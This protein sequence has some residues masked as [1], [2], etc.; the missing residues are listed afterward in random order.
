MSASLQRLRG[1]VMGAAIALS[2]APATAQPRAD[3]AASEAERAR[4]AQPVATL[5]GATITVGELEDLLNAA[6]APIRRGYQQLEARRGFLEGMLQTLLLA[7]EARRRGLDRDPQVVAAMRRRLAQR[8]EQVE[9]IEAITPESISADDVARFFEAHR[10]DYLRPEYR[11]ATAVITASRVAAVQAAIELRAAQGDMRR[12]REAVR[13]AAGDAAAVTDGDLGYFERSGAASSSDRSPVDPALA[14]AVYGLERLMDVTAAPVALADGRFAVAVM[15][16]QRPAS[17]HG[18]SDEGV[19]A[20][21]RGA[22]LRERRERREVELMREL[23]ARLRPE[24]HE[25]RLELIR[26]PPGELR[27]VPALAPPQRGDGGSR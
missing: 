13:R 2:S 15:T 16:G 22:L 26:M 19:V 3:A 8:T 1:A 23:R 21:I 4:R 18:L 10:R 14:G 24:V 5:E 9:I 17:S 11:R 7:Q 27:T 6:P 12:V 20:S 25:D